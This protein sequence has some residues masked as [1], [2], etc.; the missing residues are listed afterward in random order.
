ML[1]N[2]FRDRLPQA[3]RNMLN[4]NC[5]QNFLFLRTSAGHLPRPVLRSEPVLLTRFC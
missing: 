2:S 3:L 4:N 5:T 1:L